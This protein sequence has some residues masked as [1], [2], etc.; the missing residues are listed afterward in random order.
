MLSSL[1][2]LVVFLVQGLHA[3]QDKVFSFHADDHDALA[4]KLEGQIFFFFTNYA[5]DC[6]NIF[7]PYH[8]LFFAATMGK[9]HM[10]PSTPQDLMCNDFSI[11][12]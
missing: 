12:T 1:V 3:H 9:D 2:V 10:I 4:D 6:L 7:D 8:S 5:W 11:R